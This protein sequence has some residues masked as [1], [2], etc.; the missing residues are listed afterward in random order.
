MG[1]GEGVGEAKEWLREGSGVRVRSGVWGR[2]D[3]KGKEWSRVRGRNGVS[4]V[5]RRT[6]FY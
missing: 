5:Q 1:W 3:V 2:S 4:A 6:E